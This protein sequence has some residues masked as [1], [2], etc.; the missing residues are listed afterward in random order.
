MPFFVHSSRDLT[1]SVKGPVVRAHRVDDYVPVFQET[2]QV[3]SPKD[4]AFPSKA[5][6]VERPVLRLFQ[7]LSSTLMIP[8][9]SGGRGRTRRRRRRQML[10]VKVGKSLSRIS[11]LQKEASSLEHQMCHIPKN[12]YCDTCQRARMYRRKTT[13]KRVD[14]LADRGELELSRNSANG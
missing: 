10:T 4:L 8:A 1:V 2:I 13:K 9:M 12:R 5:V 7:M 14:P 3:A 6:A 11:K